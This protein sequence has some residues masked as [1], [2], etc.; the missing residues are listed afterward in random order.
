MAKMTDKEFK[1]AYIDM[2]WGKKG[3]CLRR[4]NIGCTLLIGIPIGIFIILMILGNIFK[5]FEFISPILQ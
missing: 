2:T 3:S 5:F 1:D 4:A